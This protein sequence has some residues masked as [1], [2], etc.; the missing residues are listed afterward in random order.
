MYFESLNYM[1]ADI[2]IHNRQ[3][4]N[5]QGFPVKLMFYAG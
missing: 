2:R 1:E 4:D 3:N 5:Y